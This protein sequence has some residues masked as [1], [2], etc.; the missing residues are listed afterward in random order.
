MHL[1]LRGCKHP[2]IAAEGATLNNSLWHFQN[3][4][5]NGVRYIKF[6]HGSLQ[7]IGMSE[8]HNYRQTQGDIRLSILWLRGCPSILQ[9]VINGGN[10]A[11]DTLDL[12]IVFLTT[13]CESA[14]ISIKISIKNCTPVF[15]AALFTKAKRCKRSKYP[16]KDEWIHKWMVYAHDVIFSLKEKGN[17]DPQ[18]NM[19]E[20]WGHYAEWNKPDMKTLYGS[21]HLRY[22]EQ[23]TSEGK[24]A[25]GWLPGDRKERDGE[26]VFSRHRVSV[27]QNEKVPQTGDGDGC[28]A[29]Y[30]KG[31][32]L[33]DLKW[34]RW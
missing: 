32:E 13:A 20:P 30:L 5:V 24:K 27:R 31:Q 12:S 10:W 23:W 29:R 4:Y 15:M 14:I 18:C 9:N 22:L 1:A 8:S 11:E 21:F 33:Y 25:E 6:S 26:L 7:P 28:T 19:N 17:S 34:P 3:C 16:S 2:L